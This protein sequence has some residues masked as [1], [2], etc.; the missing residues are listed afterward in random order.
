[1][2]K[3]EI[4]KEYILKIKEYSKH[5]KLYFE[6]NKP[7]I[8]DAKFDQLKKEILNLENKYKFLKIKSSAV[9]SV[10]YKPSKSF[11]KYTHKTPML[12]LSNAFDVSD[13]NNFEKK[14]FNFLNKRFQ[15]NYSVEPKIDGISASLTYKNNKLIYGVSRGDGN[16]GELITENLKTIKDIPLIV[17]DKNFPQEIEIRGEVFIKKKDFFNLKD[18]F[19]NPRNA[20]SGSLRQ[21]NPSE[22]KKIPLNFIAYTFGY[23]KNNIFQNQ[24]DFLQNLQKWGFKVNNDNKVLSSI[25]DLIKYHKQFEENRFNLDYDVDGLVYKVNDLN[26]QNRLGFTSNAPR[27]AIA[28]KFSAD[29]ANTKVLSID[30]QVGRTGALTPVAKVQPV[31]IG[32]V[33][34][35]NATLHNEEEIKRKDIRVGDLVKIERAGDVI[36]HVIEVDK[37]KREKK[38]KSFIFPLNC[39]YCGSKTIKEYNQTTKKYDAVRRCAND[40]FSCEK[41]AIEKIK[42]FISKEALNIEGFGKK[43]VEKF[44]DLNIIKAPQDIFS[45]NY[46]RIASL[47]GWGTLSANNLKNSIQNSKMITLQKFI[48]SIGIRHIGIE[49]SKL[50]SDNLKSIEKFIEI[51]KNKN[52][53]R[54]L[55]ID[56]IGETQVNSLK[57]FFSSKENI[58]IVLKLIH[59][60]NIEEEK[61]NKTGVLKN[62]NFMFTGKLNG[63]SRAEAKSMIEKNSGNIISSINKKLNYLVVGEKPTKRKLDQAKNLGISIIS[64]DQFKKLLN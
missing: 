62:K 13:L 31:N 46:K 50:I 57:N 64:Q 35:S 7:I 60:L 24:S 53:E 12:S 51:I 23:I 47:D 21:K 20:A 34:V 19:A 49:N 18:K 59:I 3:S 36:P 38:S 6:K 28:H 48:Y 14:I 15:I 1:M 45:L 30:I 8:T 41:V 2:N 61:I 44:W 43:V 5:N 42:H 39:P 16:I 22:T 4:K 26:L 58:N 54:F 9:S 10:G 56:G 29:S 40:G 17:K 52:F 25:S 55:N 37:S 32:G 33:V 63:I 27:W 11:E